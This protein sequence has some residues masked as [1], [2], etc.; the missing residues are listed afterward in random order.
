MGYY[1]PTPQLTISGG[2]YNVGDKLYARWSRYRNGAAR[3]NA[4]PRGMNYY[5]EAQ[6]H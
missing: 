2:I 5:T 4:S 1:K 6:V 3:I